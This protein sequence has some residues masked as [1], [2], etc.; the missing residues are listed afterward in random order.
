MI[1]LMLRGHFCDIEKCSD[2][3]LP[4]RFLIGFSHPKARYFLL[5]RQKKVSKEKAARLP[6]DPALLGFVGGRRGKRG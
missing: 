2:E 1:Y 6:L 4:R 3:S 5:L